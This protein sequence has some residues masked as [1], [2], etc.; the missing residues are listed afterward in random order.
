M[1]KFDWPDWGIYKRDKCRCVYC[2]LDGK[3]DF[4]IFRQLEIDH[5]VPNKNEL[6]YDFMANRVV[7]CH[8]CNN[9]KGEHD[10]RESA[11]YEPNDLT[12]SS[13][14]TRARLHIMRKQQRLLDD[15]LQLLYEV[16]NPE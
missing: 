5:L 14:I 7:S 16:E 11:T 4:A 1:S 13:L 6:F 15:Y 12:R 10:P 8:N 9:L 3:A 2:G